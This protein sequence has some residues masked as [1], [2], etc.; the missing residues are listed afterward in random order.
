[1]A[2]KSA[3]SKADAGDRSEPG[4]VLLVTAPSGHTSTLRLER[5][6]ISLG[7]SATNTLSFPE[8][9][10]LSRQH[11]IVDREGDQWFVQNLASKNG[12][13]VNGGL[14]T[15]R[16]ILEPGDRITASCVTLALSRQSQ[17]DNLRFDSPDTEA[18]SSTK[19]TSLEEVLSAGGSQSRVEDV[20]RGPHV[21]ALWAFVRAG[22]ELV[23]R[24]PLQELFRIILDLS[25]EAVG[26]ERGVL[27]TL[28]EGDRLVVQASRG[29][30]LQISSRVREKVLK[31]KTSLLVTDALD[32]QLVKRS[33]TIIEQGV[34]SLIAVPLQTEERVIGLM[35][36]DSVDQGPTFTSDDLILLTAM[37][38]V[39]GI[40]I[41]R[42]RWE[43]QRRMLIAENVESLG[44]L[45]AALSHELNTP[46]GTLK[47]TVD[48][49]VR[50]AA[51]RGSATPEERGRLEAVQADLR[52]SFDA[53]LER[54]DE[55]IGRIQ[56]FTNLDRA[57]V[58]AIDLNELLS[59]IVALAREPSIG[60]ELHSAPLPSIRCHRQSLSSSL[61]GLLR[62]AI[63]ACRQNDAY[64]TIVI[65]TEAMG[66][67]IE[68]RIEDNGGGMTPD[69][70]TRLF[71]PVFQIADGRISTGDWSLFTARQFVQKQGGEIRVHSQLGKGSTFVVSVP[72]K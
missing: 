66:D 19:S 63:A 14:V 25:L 71:N 22:R 17:G 32:D 29:S 72:S 11:L 27:L 6:R 64:G 12:T 57:E 37:A 43:M 41:E 49:L 45:A 54:M 9:E 40:R 33:Q 59:D 56:R 4:L 28:D 34:H 15:R 38:N 47:S 31:E 3:S 69:Q 35:Y 48:T 10:G 5:R 51:R 55:V 18:H 8:D 46:L 2:R 7:R 23:V 24:R 68:I 67:R 52:K 58:Q 53:A 26:A 16:Q 44:R 20:A 61:T 21:G 50:A 13:F 70:V 62:C 42:E 39:A 36:L 1:M 65:T 30:E 60:I